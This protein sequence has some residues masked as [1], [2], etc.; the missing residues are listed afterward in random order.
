[1]NKKNI[2]LFAVIMLAVL[3][4][5]LAIMIISNRT[6]KMYHSEKEAQ[7][8]AFVL[9]EGNITID[10]SIIPRR[11]PEMA[12]YSAKVPDSILDSLKNEMSAG[13]VVSI[14]RD[15]AI[16]YAEIGY[17]EPYGDVSE[18]TDGKKIKEIEKIIFSFFKL[19]RASSSAVSVSYRISSASEYGSGQIKAVVEEYIGEIRSE[20]TLTAVISGGKT[21]RLY[22]SAV[23]IRPT[24]QYSA[25]LCNC[26]DL[27]V[28]EKKYFTSN[29]TK[30]MTI[31]SVSYTYD[32]CFDVLGTAYLIPAC[33]IEYT[34]GTSH[35]YDLVSGDLIRTY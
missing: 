14:G 1:M 3:N 9:S 16:D 12:V 10:P 29:S 5:I 20:N 19:N 31:N 28:K 23:I 30:Y 8:L 7:E 15:F 32:T 6:E 2:T 35:L 34:D 4:V 24:E 11:D 25:K 13:G 17:R 33:R 27:L 22:G 18:I 26:F 21:V